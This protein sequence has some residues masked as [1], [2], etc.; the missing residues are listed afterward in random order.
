MSEDA[1]T[2]TQRGHAERREDRLEDA[3]QTFTEA[4]AA[5]RR[6]GNDI[7]LVPAL[8]GLGQIERDLG[9]RE[10]A[11]ELYEEAAELC[12]ANED[13]SGLAHT[14]RHLGDMH[15]DAG[16]WTQADEYYLQALGLYRRDNGVTPL[17][18]ANMLR[19]L[20]Q[21]RERL[22]ASAEAEPLW[23][24]ARALYLAAG[25]AEGAAE[26]DRHLS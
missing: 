10:R 12:L 5:A 20:A 1:H 2:L 4:V 26:C 3:R 14:L 21:L 23:R 15:Q 8:K 22:G 19:P 18:L 24:E 16:N 13:L 9:Q 7:D 6:A 25:V 11:V 17:E